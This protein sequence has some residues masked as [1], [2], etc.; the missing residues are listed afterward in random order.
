MDQRDTHATRVFRE[1]FRNVI[2]ITA[3]AH[4]L[5]EM[6]AADS[7]PAVQVPHQHRFN[8]YGENGG[9]AIAIAGA[10][11]AIVAS[12]TRQ[13]EGYSINSRY[14]P[15]AFKL[16]VPGVWASIESP[17][18]T[19]F[20]MLLKRTDQAV[21][22]SCG[23]N[24]DTSALVK[25]LEQRLTQY[26][27]KHDKEMPTPAIAQLLSITLYHKR[28][29]PY[30]VSNILAGL[31]PEGKSGGCYLLVYRS[32]ADK[33]EPGKGA[34]YSY[35]GVGSYERYNFQA[36]GTANDLVQ[37]LL[38]SQVGYKNTPEAANPPLLSLEKALQLAKDVFTSATERDIYTGDMLEIFIVTKDG[39]RVEQHPLK[40]D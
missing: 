23:F 18:L 16:Y 19:H 17:C 10:D 28:F 32:L 8:P 9:T 3:T 27:F 13:S 31:D 25:T 29:F 2:I 5:T 38:D 15:K 20:A 24:A 21:L 36:A 14:V 39:V 26:R 37:P 22:A 4:T 34:V 12:D 6:L 40:K 7:R 35:D 33:T 11:F 30:Y 1:E